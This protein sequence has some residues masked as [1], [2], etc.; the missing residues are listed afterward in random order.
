MPEGFAFCGRCGAPL[1]SGSDAEE[2]RVVTVLFC[3]VVGF[4]AR[5]DRADPEDV[6]AVLRPYHARLRHEIERFGGTLDKFIGD[7]VMAIFG[8]P[9]AHEDDPERAV[10]SGLAI[11]QAVADLNHAQADLDLKVRVGINSGE[12]V[13]AWDRRETETVIGDVVNT[14]SRLEGV[15][16]VGGVVVGEPTFQ[17][18]RRVFDYQPLPPVRVKGK[19][20]PLH[21]WRAISARSRLGFVTDQA[22]ISPFLG[23]AAEL[24]R[25]QATYRTTRDEVSVQLV[26]V[27]GEPG[28]GKSR[29][30]REFHTFV[31]RQPDLIIWRQGHCLPYGEGIS[32]WALGEVL[33]AHAGILEFDAPSTAAAKLADAVAAVIDD[34]AERQW[35]EAR[36]APMVGLAGEIGAA[37][38]TPERE[39]AFAAW[40]RF[41]EAMA[42]RRPLVVV[43][44]DLHWADDAMLAFIQDL[45]E[46]ASGVSL[47]VVGTARL[48]LYDHAPDWG[49]LPG[50]ATT[51]T[52]GPLSD[53]DTTRLLASLLGRAVLPAELQARLLVQVGGNPL[54]AEQVCWMLEEQG[55]LEPDG[56]MGVFP[57][58]I[59][60][61]IAAR[62]D[63]LPQ[64][65]RALLQNAA[66][67]G[68]TFWPGALSTLTGRDPATIQADLQ[69][70]ARRAFIRRADDS[71]VAG[72]T[73]YA[74]WHAVT[75]DVV[76]G[77]LPRMA[78]IQKHRAVAH[79]IQQIVGERV[80]D[81]AE[82]LTHHYLTALELAKAA[83]ALT[84]VA[85]L[86]D[87]AIESLILAGDRAMQL[88]AAR[89]DLHYQ[90]A[91]GLLP[92]DYPGR[93]KVLANAAEAARQTNRTDQAE[94]LLSQAIAEFR[95]RGDRLGAGDAMVRQANI[96][97]HRGETERGRTTVVAALELLEQEPP[98][99]ELA[100]AFLE[101]GKDIHTSGRPAEALDWL[102]KAT[103]LADRL[104]AEEIRQQ[105]LQY[106]GCARGELGDLDGLNDV[107]EAVAL[108]LQLG[109]GRGTTVAYG[110]LASEL[111]EFDG[112]AAAM[113]SVQVGLSFSQVRGIT[114]QTQWLSVSKVEC[115]EELGQWDEALRLADQL[116]AS[117]GDLAQSYKAILL[118][119]SKAHIL[120]CRGQRQEADAH[121]DWFLSHSRH[122]GDLQV[123]AHVFPIAALTEQAN[124]DLTAAI[125]L[126]QELERMTQNGPPCY[127]AQPL[128]DV[129]R[130]CKAAG[131]PDLIERFME[132]ADAPAARYQHSL[133]TG[134]AILAE[135]QGKLQEAARLYADAGDRWR[136]FGVVLEHGQALLS[137]GRCATQL[138]Q[139][140]ARD[141]LLD[142]RRVFAQLRA[143]PLLAETDRW[144]HHVAVKSG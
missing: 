32:F 144:L 16:P 104:G 76:Y 134:R 121:K 120:L 51:I 34:Q 42:A 137:L 12:A 25:L 124:G 94:Q 69:E 8:A 98:G 27:V 7:G 31:D 122:I 62:L 53:G 71:S 1:S 58:S 24:E 118:I 48:E 64:E 38:G 74:F 105:A 18:T 15:A 106:R 130:I 139:P 96:Y 4:T 131:K 23:R 81:H 61:L 93:A 125:Q 39:E 73:E 100:A 92:T 40:R 141:W 30:V 129:A 82:L 97:W 59:Q 138:G 33:K 78:R 55:L 26:T 2:R 85:Q 101:M 119:P 103:D 72:E 84:E 17:A 56:R 46:N 132:G 109:L 65:P 142:A 95:A 41:L 117:S 114:E 20:E 36:L 3:D 70:L 110:N 49:N 75:R 9:V 67:V 107:R 108:G 11:Q 57:D 135:A 52:L 91:L 35:V 99:R 63:T 86:Q 111:W 87:Q 83:R 47:L 50:K 28:V 37:Q 113:R 88:D 29:L 22:P 43:L 140:P 5:S 143:R 44:E 60:A 126:V 6:R 13:V 127:R 116:L 128:P 102:R 77:Q 123:L 79:W 136:N 45:V 80:T 112:P 90:R 133:V 19:A 14:A 89:A 66:V 21:I 10:R 115:L 54:Y 68:T